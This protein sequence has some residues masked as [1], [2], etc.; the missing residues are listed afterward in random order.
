MARLI[1]S[2]QKVRLQISDREVAKTKVL[3]IK[4]YVYKSGKYFERGSPIIY[5]DQTGRHQ[6]HFVDCA[7][8]KQTTYVHTKPQPLSNNP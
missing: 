5:N 3:S 2:K 8:N 6:H 1:D 4:G 7:V